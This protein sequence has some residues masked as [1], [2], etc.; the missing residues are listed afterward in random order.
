M[1]VDARARHYPTI[2]S[3]CCENYCTHCNKH[4]SLAGYV[5]SEGTGE[6]I[7]VTDNRRSVHMGICP[8]HHTPLRMH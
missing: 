2:P 1:F 6:R 8:V 5:Q 3:L 4:Y 7:L